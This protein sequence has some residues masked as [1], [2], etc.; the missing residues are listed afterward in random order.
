MTQEE[1]VANILAQVAKG[2]IADYP[3]EADTIQNGSIDETA[4]AI[5]KAVVKYYDFTPKVK[6]LVWEWKLCKPVGCQIDDH[7]KHLLNRIADYEIISPIGRY[8]LDYTNQ[9]KWDL[10]FNS[11]L[12]QSDCKSMQKTIP[13][14]KD[15]YRTTVLSLL[16]I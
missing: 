6:E 1:R 11:E 3:E 2:L 12:I 15:H 4:L 13:I 5:L 14:I 16:E 10:Y 9:D 8:T 7:L